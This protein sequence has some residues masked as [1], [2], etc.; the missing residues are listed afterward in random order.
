MGRGTSEANRPTSNS[1]GNHWSSDESHPARLASGD[2][3]TRAR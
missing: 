3:Y 1:A 2:D